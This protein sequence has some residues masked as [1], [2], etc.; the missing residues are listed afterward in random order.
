M[1]QEPEIKLIETK[2]EHCNKDTQQVKK[3]QG[4]IT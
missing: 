4:R 1:Q 3:A 2:I